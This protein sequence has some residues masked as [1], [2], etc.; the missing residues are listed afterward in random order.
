M[1]SR[2]EHSDNMPQQ[3]Y[4]VLITKLVQNRSNLQELYSSASVIEVVSAHCETSRIVS[5]QEVLAH[6]I[7]SSTVQTMHTVQCG[8]WS[9]SAMM[10]GGD[11]TS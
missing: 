9:G 7:Q 11:D 8:K 4:S 10:R 6:M 1:Q 5:D 2:I 3:R